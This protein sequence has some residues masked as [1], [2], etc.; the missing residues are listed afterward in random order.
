MD[1]I[2]IL[3]ESIKKLAY[4]DFVLAKANQTIQLELKRPNISKKYF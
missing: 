3:K 4:L 2:S 1:N